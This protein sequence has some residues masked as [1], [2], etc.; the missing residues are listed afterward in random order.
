MCVR[1]YDSVYVCLCPCLFVRV[2]AVQQHVCLL[3]LAVRMQ[4][5]CVSVSL[6]VRYV[7]VCVYGM[8]LRV[9]V[10]LLQ[11]CARWWLGGRAGAGMFLLFVVAAA[12]DTC[13]KTS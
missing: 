13:V 7:C 1:V 11:T 8:R 2:W 3:C 6:L 10:R 9:F 4:D 12:C 5:C